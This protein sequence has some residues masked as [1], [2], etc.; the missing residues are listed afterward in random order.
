MI[1]GQDVHK[2]LVYV[3]RMENDRKITEQYQIKN[4]EESW[5]KFVGKYILEMPEIALEASPSGK[6][7]INIL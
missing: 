1:I 6:H 7:K 4:S 5:N 3:T 2:D